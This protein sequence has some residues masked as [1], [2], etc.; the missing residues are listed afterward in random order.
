MYGGTITSVLINV[1]GESSTVMTAIDGYQMALKGRAGPA[2]SISALGSFVAGTF[3][4]VLLTVLAI[5][6]TAVALSFGPPEYFM[7]MLLGLATLSVMLNE[8][9]VRGILG[10][11]LGLMIGAVGLDVI[12]AA[13]RFTFGRLE[14]LDGIGFLAIAV[15]LFG[16]G[17]V[18]AGLEQYY[19]M[20]PIKTSLRD[21]V[22]TKQDIKDSTGPIWRGTILG[23]IIGVLPGAGA[24]I[25]S[26]MSYALEKRISKHPEK[27]GT[28]A[29]EGVA[30]PEASN[31]ASTGGGML[32]LLTLGIPGS[33]TTAVMLGA[34]IL[35]GLQPGPLLFEK[36]PDFV[37]GVIASMYIGNVM[38]V[39]LN[40][41]FVPV[42]VRALAIPYPVL[43]AFIVLF[44]IVGVYS[45]DYSVFDLWIMLVAGVVGYLMRKLEFP[46]APV[47][48]ALVLGP[49]METNLRQS[50]L[51]S[52]GSFGI[53]LTR[54]ISL[55]LAILTV[56][57]VFA[58]LLLSTFTKTALPPPDEE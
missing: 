19:E 32:P 23:F 37:W 28:G 36:N 50:L 44:C 5:P 38:L 35:F 43:A 41:V 2:L 26:F 51:M 13:P 42:F 14:L 30:G 46:P 33:S 17:E 52:Q 10:A 56:L 1:P 20:K 53:F 29:I 58:P 24:T 57:F 25:A 48:L 34:M 8:N 16:I 15:G 3:S 27:F 6:L 54:P 7:L 9:K 4:V 45:V 47:V 55:I 12:S 22:L 39:I 18:L 21:L 49:M 31:N 40:I 11:L